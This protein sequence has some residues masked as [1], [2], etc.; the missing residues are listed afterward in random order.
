MSLSLLITTILIGLLGIATGYHLC[1]AIRPPRVR[2][3]TFVLLAWGVIA[4]V[5]GGDWSKQSPEWREA[6]SAW[7]EANGFR[8]VDRED[9]P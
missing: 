5:S 9:R 4:N 1:L 6:A 7:A 2:S 3:E 8:I